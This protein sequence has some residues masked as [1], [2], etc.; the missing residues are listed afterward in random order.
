[1]KGMELS[2]AYFEEYG[3][4]LI[5]GELREY[6]E[7]IAAGLAGEGSECLG[8]DDGISQD[9][10]FGPAFCIWVP[11][12]VFRQAGHLMQVAYDR[13]PRTYRGYTRIT[14]EQ[15]GGRVGVLTIEDYYRKFTG[16]DRA[17]RDNMEWMRIPERFLAVAVSGEVFLDHYGVFSEI[18]HALKSFYPEDV[19][20]KKLAARCA[21]MAQ[22]GQYNYGRSMKRGDSQA[23]YFACAEFVKKAMS[24]VYLLNEVYMPYYKWIFKGAE[25]FQGMEEMVEKLKTLTV[26]PDTAE[27]H[28]AKEHLIEEVCGS[29]IGEL[30]RR[31]LTGTTDTFL[32]AHG[33]ELMRSIGDTRIRSLHIMADYD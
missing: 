2:K 20:K 28:V 17:P 29:F 4:P 7:Y 32:Q 31:G 24:C 10:D 1:M 8:F 30:K 27:N 6:R 13:L 19:W 21:V 11:E 3:K 23:A 15:G 16:L 25:A 14:S 5:D 12:S 26:M 18:R 22:A 33:E 9:H